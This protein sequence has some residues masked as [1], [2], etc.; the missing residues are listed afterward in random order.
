M[1]LFD[2]FPER[3]YTNRTQMER[4]LN[5]LCLTFAPLRDY[6]AFGLAL[7]QIEGPWTRSPATARWA[8]CHTHWIAVADRHVYDINADQWLSRSAWEQEIVPTLI[9]HHARAT[10]YRV[11]VGIELVRQHFS[12]QALPGFS[13]GRSRRIS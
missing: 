12:P 7:I 3:P 11:R 1:A 13:I 6:P 8:T 2:Q 10:G 5:G 4:I 9:N